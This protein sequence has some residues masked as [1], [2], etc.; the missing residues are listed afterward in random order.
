MGLAHQEG[1]GHPVPDPEKPEIRRVDLIRR[2]PGLLGA[3]L[4]RA[5]QGRGSHSFSVC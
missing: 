1:E 5:G 4:L 3:Q 2:G